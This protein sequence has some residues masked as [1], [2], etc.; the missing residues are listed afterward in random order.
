MPNSFIQLVVDNVNRC[1][2][3]SLDRSLKVLLVKLIAPG[4]EVF[5]AERRPSKAQVVKF[6]AVASTLAKK[7]HSQMRLTF[8]GEPWR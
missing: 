2:H 7:A 8:N 6:F 1:R 3:P 5:D 4:V